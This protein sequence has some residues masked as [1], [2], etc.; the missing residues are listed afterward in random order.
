MFFG[1]VS[2]G[3][4]FLLSTARELLQA[5]F[6]FMGMLMGSLVGLF[7]L[8]I[9]FPFSN[10]IVRPLKFKNNAGFTIKLFSF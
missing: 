7:T 4:A 8:A 2:I 6:S 3:M 9:Q 1:L 10:E 5:A